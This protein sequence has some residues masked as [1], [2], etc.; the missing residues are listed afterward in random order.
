[1]VSRSLAGSLAESYSAYYGQFIFPE[2]AQLQLGCL[3]VAQGRIVAFEPLETLPHTLPEGGRRLEG[4]V[5]PGLIDMHVHLLLD[6]SADP[7]GH[8]LAQNP[9][10]RV[11]AAQRHM[12][13]ELQAGVTT[14]RDLGGPDN[15]AVQLGQAVA[16]GQLLGTRIFSSGR[17]I[18]MTGGHAHVLG[19]EADGADAVRRAARTELKAG[20]GLL[21]FMATGGVLTPGVIAGAEAMTEAEM[22]AGVEEAHKLGKRTAAHAQ[23]LQGIKNAL[24]AGIDS[25]EHGAFDHWD[26]EALELLRSRCLVPT[27]AAPDAIMANRDALPAWMVAKTAPIVERHLANSQQAYQA[28]VPIV[29]GTDAGTP[30]NPHGNLPR[31][32]EL[33]ASLNLSLAEVLRSATCRAAEALGQA[34]ELGSLQTGAHADLVSW[35]H[36]P[37]ETIQAYR[38]AQARVV[39]GQL[40]A[41]AAESA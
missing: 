32:L 18:T 31:E 8:L 19:C 20:A 40:L 34:G 2:K 10:Q 22:R 13:Q 16:E 24:R 15:I 1:M 23:G 3:R 28:A 26:D 21:K 27:L 41:G 4:F 12:Q 35:Q 30:F 17:N 14:V 29:A 37:L 36:N 7:V 33:L 39:A 11:L 6:G 9:V 25:I 38:R 5:T